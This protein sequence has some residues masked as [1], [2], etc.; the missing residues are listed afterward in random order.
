MKL[1]LLGVNIILQVD[2]DLVVHFVINVLAQ[3]TAD[4]RDTLIRSVRI[5]KFG[6]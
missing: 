1:I 2:F 4:D 6:M 3:E 5:Y